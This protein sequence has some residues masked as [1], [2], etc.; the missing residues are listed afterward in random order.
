M[1]YISTL[2]K[3]FLFIDHVYFSLC[4]WFYSSNNL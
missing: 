4:V 3:I 1:Q 2:T